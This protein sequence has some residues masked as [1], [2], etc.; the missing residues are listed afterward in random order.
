MTQDFPTSGPD[1]EGRARSDGANEPVPVWPALDAAPNTSVDTTPI[2]DRRTPARNESDSASNLKGPIAERVRKALELWRT[3]LLDLSKRN[4][5]LNFRV[6]KVSTVAVV[7]E[8]PAEV[9]RHLCID[10]KPMRFKPMVRSAGTPAS[11]EPELDLPGSLPA[12]QAP[13]PMEREGDADAWVDPDGADEPRSLELDYAPYDPEALDDRH[14]DDLLQVQAT[15]EALDKSLRRLDDLSRATL[16]EQGVN[17]LYLALGMLHYTESAASEEVFRAPLLMVP[18]RLSRRSARSGYAVEATDEEPIVNPALA[19]YL[20]REYAIQLPE[21]PASDDPAAASAVRDFFAA[22][23]EIAAE[24][25]RAGF[26]AWAVKTDIYLGVFAFQKLVMFKDV[27]ANADAFSGHRLVGQLVSREAPAGTYLTGLPADIRDIP[28]DEEFPPERTAQVVD[29]DSSQ[30]RAIAAVARGH[31]L[32]IEGPPGT[33]KSQTI[34]NLIAQALFDGKSVL[35]VAEKLAALQVV[36]DR[37]VRAGLGEFCLE[38]HASKANKR[39]VMQELKFALDASLQR[40][41]TERRTHRLPHVRGE[42]SSYAAAVHAPHGALGISPYRATG[43]LDAVRD[44]PRIRLTRS[45]DDITPERLEDSERLLGDLAAAQSAIGIPARHPWR[46]TSRVFYTPAALEDAAQSLDQLLTLIDDV[47]VKAKVASDAFALPPAQTPGDVAAASAIADVYEQSP[48]A[49]LSVLESDAWNAPPAD[50][51]GL[52]GEVR[53]LQRQR[54]ELARK[55]S[56]DALEQDHAIDIGYVEQK[57]SGFFGFLAFLDGRYRAIK[58]RW[59]SYRVASYAPATLLDLG[60]DLKAVDRYRAARKGLSDRTERGQSLFGSLWQGETSSPAALD[61]YI[62]WVVE[63]RGICLKHGL[64]AS[65]LKR[66]AAPTPD[67]SSIRAL[68]RSASSLSSAIHAFAASVQWD[69][70]NVA[71]IPYAELRNRVSDMRVGIDM[72]P[73]WA[74]FEQARQ[75]AAESAAAEV[76]AAALK[77][78]GAQTDLAFDSLNRIFRRAVLEKWLEEVMASRPP[79]REFSTL[80]HEKRLKEFRQLDE[81]VL[82]ENQAG[83]VAKLRAAAQ[84]RLQRPEV[85]AGL[86]FLQTQMTKQRN[87]APLRRVLKQSEPAVRAIKPCFLMSPLTVAQYLDGRAPSFDLVIFDEASQLPTEDAVGAICRGKQLVV[88]GDPKQ[89]PPTNFFASSSGATA[90]GP[91]G[92]DGLP[93]VE[94]SESVLEEYMGAGLPVTRLKWHYRSAHESLITFSNVSFYDSDLYTFPSVETGADHMGL[95]FEYVADGVYEGKGLNLAEARRVV[96]AVVEHAKARPHESLGVGTFNMRQQLAI[97]DELELRRRQDPSLEPFFARGRDEGFFVKNLENIQGDERDVI[98]LSVTYAKAADGRLRYNFG[99]LNGENGWRRLNV[100][101]TRARKRMRVYSSMKGDEINAAG[102][103]SRGAHLLRDFLLYAEHGTLQSVVAN[104]AAQTDSPFEF[105]VVSELTRRGIRVVPQVGVAGY[106]IDVG[107]LDDEVLGRFVCGIECDGVT[108]HSSETARD[109]DRLRQQ[110]LE[111]RGWIIHRIWSTDWFKD[112]P[113]TI[114]RILRQI[115]EAK[116]EVRAVRAAEADA[117]AKLRA[118]AERTQREEQERV[119]REDD[120]RLASAREA[121]A[122]GPYVRPSAAPYQ[123]GGSQGRYSGSDLLETPTGLLVSAIVE[124]VNVEAPLH[125]SDLA[126]RVVGLWGTRLGA[127]I[128]QK[129]NEAIEGAVR[130]GAVTRRGEFIWSKKLAGNQAEVPVRSRLG[131]KLPGDRVAPE[132][133][134][135]AVRLVLKAAGGLTLD[136]L[137]SEVR[138]VLGVSR[139]SVAPSVE[140]AVAAGKRGGWLGEGSTGL[141]LRA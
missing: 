61:R 6:T 51:T 70:G 132:E 38:L 47:L 62:A 35:F 119:A 141:A 34:T 20:R 133:V 26:K 77:N 53:E 102:T 32:V 63:V 121:L 122:A 40:P 131:T 31:D 46:D 8:Q 128:A 84:E 67:V 65:S 93:I 113:N 12:L 90:S 64:S 56:L 44:V 52:V 103:T 2:A 14:R 95:S 105:E 37:L 21:L 59:N 94:D 134:E 88:V 107:V 116:R 39:E 92:D 126:T 11:I 10:A 54:A 18:V 97:L 5:G 71:A 139:A 135:A 127:R 45:I 125:S 68:E 117:D 27:E 136:E 7:D 120:L 15:P 36:H 76:V 80:S 112:R 16:E 138:Q 108:Y 114:D 78:T 50:A 57:M 25:V 74:A 83:V 87:I 115:D 86:P 43:M 82:K 28:L 89:L 48:G 96:D 33:G 49:P 1:S 118:E 30:L 24:R 3:R 4:R 100:I 75:K 124:I 42:L 58:R 140:N 19:E 111:A 98:F 81:W 60:N 85:R 72:A 137:V 106:R 69:L 129:V 123:L 101:T 99:P 9:F 66:A 17:V 13:K 79:L 109:R 41:V 73:A 110:V 29:A 22:A 23:T 91:V 130:G 55:F 104:A